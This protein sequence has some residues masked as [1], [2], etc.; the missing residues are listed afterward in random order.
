MQKE[1][2]KISSQTSGM[3][4]IPQ[5]DLPDSFISSPTTVY[6]G[7]IQPTGVR[8]PG[9]ITTLSSHLVKEQRYGRK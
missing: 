7:A 5:M 4:F 9:D 1:F 2:P 6:V 3:S 8:L